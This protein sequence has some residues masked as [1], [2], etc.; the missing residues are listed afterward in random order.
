MVST[1]TPNIN[2]EEPARGDDV[3]TW[4]TPVNNNSTLIDLVAGGVAT[5]GVNNANITLSAA[6]FQSENI[7]FNSTLTGS[8]SITFPTSFKK[9]YTIGN[10]A[11]GSSAFT[12]TLTTTA[13]GGQ[14][15]C[16]PPGEY[17]ECFND[18]A[19]LRYRNLGRVG[20]YITI[21]GTSV[22]NWVSGCTVAPY[23]NCDGT[24]FSATTYP[25]LAVRLGGT[26]L[27]DARGRFVAAM[28]QGTGRMTSAAGGVDGNT[29]LAA[30]GADTQTLTTGQIPSGLIGN[31]SN[32]FNI[33]TSAT[34]RTLFGG[35]PGGSLVAGGSID[36]PQVGSGASYTTGL[37]AS[38]VVGSGTVPVQITNALGQAHPIMPPTVIGGLTLIR[39]G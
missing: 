4:D 39:A 30:G 25:A 20:E 22:P 37:Q 14:A 35:S 15:I 24:S 8:I 31:N 33:N 13:S 29:L 3:G 36:G 11:T 26:T 38:G 18:G 7:T 23:L 32:N 34:G 28:N 27:P 19:N 9:P 2:I 10:L 6:Q 12:I 1:F 16:A 5:V 17:I 21:A